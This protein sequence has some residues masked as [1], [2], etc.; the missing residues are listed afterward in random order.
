MLALFPNLIASPL[1]GHTL[2]LHSHDAE[3]AH[4]HIAE[5]AGDAAHASGFIIDHAAEHRH[6]DGESDVQLASHPGQSSAGSGPSAEGVVVKL[7]DG[8]ALVSNGRNAPTCMLPLAPFAAAWVMGRV[9]LACSTADAAFP[10][11]EAPHDSAHGSIALIM[12]T[13]HAILI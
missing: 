11:A 8:A 3:G 1:F 6:H 5:S 12:R 10:F 2:L 4:C 7:P 13:N 9:S